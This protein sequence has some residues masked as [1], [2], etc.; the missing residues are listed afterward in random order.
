MSVPERAGRRGRP[1]SD[2]CAVAS[3]DNSVICVSDVMPSP[4]NSEED[5]VFTDADEEL[6]RHLA[7]GSGRTTRRVSVPERVQG[8][9]RPPASSAVSQKR[10]RVSSHGHG[11]PPSAGL[12]DLALTQIKGLIEAGNTTVIQKLERLEA[13]LA[14]FENRLDKIEHDGFETASKTDRLQEDLQQLRLENNI[15]REQLSSIDVNNRQDSLILR[16]EDFGPRML[17]EDIE[18]KTVCLL[19][20]K[21]EWLQVSR[22]DFQV[23]HRLQTNNTVICKFL[24]RSIRDQIYD[25]RFIQNTRGTGNRL[26][27]TES[28][29]A[30]NRELMNM[31]LTAKREGRIYTCFTRR[32][33]PFFKERFDSSSRRVTSVEQI[34][35]ILDAPLPRPQARPEPR[36]AGWRGERGGGRAGGGRGGGGHGGS[37]GGRGEGGAGTCQGGDE[38]GGVRSGGGVG[39]GRSGGGRGEAGGDWSGGGASRK[40]VQPVGATVCDVRSCRDLGAAPSALSGAA[41]VGGSPGGAQTGAAADPAAGP[42]APGPAAP[43]PAESLTSLPL[44]SAPEPGTVPAEPG[45]GPAEVRDNVLPDGA[46]AGSVPIC[47]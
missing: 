19:N 4:I 12:D 42:S 14:S 1:G 37:V 44:S 23:V 2:Y 26:F 40:T 5:S 46:A 36:S 35:P 15:L 21:F 38:P 47:D 43:G 31:L 30:P 17:N 11:H 6:G 34:K 3:Q 33:C 28:L 45:G 13:R 16:C 10:R 7:G 18:D 25:S 41:D 22:G 8:F 24:R 9:E 32:G 27:I 20:S 29:S 39:G